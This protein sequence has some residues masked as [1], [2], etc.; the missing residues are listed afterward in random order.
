[1]ES[2]RRGGWVNWCDW[3]P[4]AR[5]KAVIDVV[6]TEEGIGSAVWGFRSQYLAGVPRSQHFGTGQDI[7]LRGG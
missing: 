1:M 5:R 4:S 7:S 2:G 3:E 6:E